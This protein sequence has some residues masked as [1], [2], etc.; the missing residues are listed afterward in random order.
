MRPASGNTRR[1]NLA[2]APHRKSRNGS[3]TLPRLLTRHPY[4][5]SNLLTIY[6]TSPSAHPLVNRQKKI[7][8]NP[9]K[10]RGLP[11][12]KIK[13][14]SLPPQTTKTGLCQHLRAHDPV[15]DELHALPKSR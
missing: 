5:Q 10:G 15:A 1:K 4:P 2:A 7:I 3:D 14:R 13:G 6:R 11:N 8:L 9:P 12:S